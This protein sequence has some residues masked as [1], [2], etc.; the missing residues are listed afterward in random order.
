MGKGEEPEEPT[1]D[2][3]EEEKDGDVRDELM[4]EIDGMCLGEVCVN[5]RWDEREKSWVR[6]SYLHRHGWVRPT[7]GKRDRAWTI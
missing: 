7:E 3:T 6:W 5:D 1:E 2:D 4:D